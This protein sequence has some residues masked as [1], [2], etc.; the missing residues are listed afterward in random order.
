MDRQY[1]E[2]MAELI[3][4]EVHTM[5]QTAYEKAKALLKDNI[6]LLHKLAQRLIDHET[7]EG[8]ALRAITRYPAEILGLGDKLGTIEEGKIGNLVITDGNPLQIR[9]QVMHVFVGGHP[10]SL[11]NKHLTLY[12][13]YRARQ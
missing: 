1:G 5:V 12:E 4:N 6:E 13:R 3:D 11:D 7:V 9:T 8:E 10:A 2:D